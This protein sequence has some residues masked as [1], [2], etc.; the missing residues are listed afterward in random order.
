MTA[1]PLNLLVIKNAQVNAKLA[2]EAEFHEFGDHVDNVALNATAATT[3]FKPVSGNS[4][5]AVGDPDETI[6][7][8]MAQDLKA[9]S[10]WLFCRTNHGK[11]GVVEIF[12]KGGTTPKITADVI[13]Q[14]PAALGGAVG[15]STSGA[16]FPVEGQAD[17][18]PES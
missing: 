7:L 2:G 6:V 15:A 18:T 10:L 9:G 3:L 8:N 13:F 12:P 14:T 16:T 11:K 4:Q 17:I 5:A 1:V